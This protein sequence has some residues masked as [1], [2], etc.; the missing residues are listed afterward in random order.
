M[1]LV[2]YLITYSNIDDIIERHKADKMLVEAAS[3]RLK[4]P[5]PNIGE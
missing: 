2:N 4:S 5:K 1:K 3:I